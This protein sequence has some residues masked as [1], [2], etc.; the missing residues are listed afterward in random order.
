MANNKNNIQAEIKKV[1]SQLANDGR[2][3]VEKA[4]NT[5]TFE[6]RTYNLHDSYGSAVYYN[7]VLQKDS[8]YYLSPQATA[9]KKWYGAMLR[10]KNE[11]VDFF[12]EYRGIGKGFD[13]VVVA[14][15]PYASILEHGQGRLRQKYKVIS[16]AMSDMEALA[17][18]YN[19]TITRSSTSRVI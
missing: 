5:R 17:K 18:K 16:G 7:G 12:L 2:L 3:L 8:I 19:G 10:G 9:A 11:I 13:L 14:A 6:N 4:Y 15:M 1:V